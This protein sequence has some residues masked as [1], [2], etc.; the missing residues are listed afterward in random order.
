[1]VGLTNNT[2]FYRDAVLFGTIVERTSSQ[3]SLK[4]YPM[5]TRTVTHRL[6]LVSVG[7]LLVVTSNILLVTV[8]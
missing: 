4:Q 6:R 3:K 8:I 7:W 2:Q 5:C 1:M